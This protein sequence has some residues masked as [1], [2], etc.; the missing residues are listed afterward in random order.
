MAYLNGGDLQPVEQ[1]PASMPTTAVLM[2]DALI[3][4]PAYQEDQVRYQL[5]LGHLS[6]P[7][8]KLSLVSGPLG[9]GKTL[10]LRAILGEA[11]KLQGQIYADTTERDALPLPEDETHVDE[12]EWFTRGMVYVPQ[13]AYIRH[14]SI[15]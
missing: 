1:M 6:F 15:R 7:R 14:A 5:Y 10:L 11:Q 2:A 8:G 12:A 13:T 3:T 9:S 4:W